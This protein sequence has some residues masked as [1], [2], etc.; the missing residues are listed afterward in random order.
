MSYTT[1]KSIRESDPACIISETKRTGDFRQE[2]PKNAGGKLSGQG[3]GKVRANQKR[4][5]RRRTICNRKPPILFLHLKL[6]RVSLHV[7]M[8]LVHV[9]LI[10]SRLR[11][12]VK[13]SVL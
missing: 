10:F 8:V 1:D 3:K 7:V 9:I 6:A 4:P 11:F 5:A 13:F 12:G 2:G